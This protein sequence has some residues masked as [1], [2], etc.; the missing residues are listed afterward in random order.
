MSSTYAKNNKKRTTFPQN[1][2][3]KDINMR[4]SA[5]Q[6]NPYTID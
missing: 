2:S 5:N 4:G 1:D 3:L 6:T